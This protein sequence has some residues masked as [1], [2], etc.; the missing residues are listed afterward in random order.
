MSGQL[1]Y[2]HTENIGETKTAD[3]YFCSSCKKEVLK[4]IR[5]GMFSG[6]LDIYYGYCPHCGARMDGGE[7]E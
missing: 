1:L 5:F 3:V 2:H 7:S 4:K 6:E